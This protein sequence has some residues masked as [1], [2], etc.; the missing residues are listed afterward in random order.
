[1]KF[2]KLAL[3]ILIFTSCSEKFTTVD[4][5]INL[6]V[7]FAKT[8]IPYPKNDFSILIPTL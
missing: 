7:K 2:I 5:Y 4:E 3:I 8:K 6:P 1:M